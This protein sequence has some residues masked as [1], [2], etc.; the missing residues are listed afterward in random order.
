MF[1]YACVIIMC[2]LRGRRIRICFTTR[3]HCFS[4]LANGFPETRQR[5]WNGYILF[6]DRID[7]PAK[8]P[9]TPRKGTGASA[10]NSVSNPSS[11]GIVTRSR[12]FRSTSGGG[13]LSTTPN[14][15]VSASVFYFKI[16]KISIFSI[17]NERRRC[18]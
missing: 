7:D 5:Y 6:Y 14:K 15:L 4:I 3:K 12:S 18:K 10:S 13:S 8:T 11:G 16:F 17:P 2:L 9:R 1:C